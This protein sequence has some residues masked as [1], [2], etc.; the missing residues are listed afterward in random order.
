M[1]CGDS[2]DREI[3]LTG[4]LPGKDWGSQYTARLA[5]LLGGHLPGLG[6]D[7]ANEREALERI[8]ELVAGIRS[9]VFAETSLRHDDRTALLGLLNSADVQLDGV[10]PIYEEWSGFLCMRGFPE[11]EICPW[12]LSWGDDIQTWY[13]RCDKPHPGEIFEDAAG[14]MRTCPPPS[15]AIDR[16]SA[17]NTIRGLA[18]AAVRFARCAQYWLAQW[19][20]WVDALATYEPELQPWSSWGPRTDPDPEPTSP[21]IGGLRSGPIEPIDPRPGPSPEGVE[22]MPVDDPIWDPDALPGI[23]IPQPPDAGAAPGDQPPPEADE[24]HE[25]IPTTSNEQIASV[26]TVGLAAGVLFLL[27]KKR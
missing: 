24:G 15:I 5:P 25:L 19:G 23:P 20:L 13:H 11:S 12:P 18:F 2:W 21:G 7:T 6:R 22:A 4:A 1:A 27:L 10:A 14:R 17:R 8:R 26:V 16:Q 3:T 9:A